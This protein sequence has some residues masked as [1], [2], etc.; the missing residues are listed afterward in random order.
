M[1]KTIK[2]IFVLFLFSIKLFAQKE[3]QDFCKGDVKGS[4]F[5]LEISK[6][7]I[8]W[9]TTSYTEEL[10]GEK[11]IDGNLY[12]VF[13]QLWENGDKYTLYLREVNN[14][15]FEY[16]LKSKKDFIRY[17]KTFD[18]NHTWK[19]PNWGNYKLLS[20]TDKLATPYCVYNNLMSIE[21]KINKQTY[22]FYYLKGYGYVGAVKDKTVISYVSPEVKFD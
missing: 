7:K 9:Y 10:I 18:I 17:D 4:Y 8:H 6:K 22:I 16:D 1:N 11:N 3:G 14:I 21:V 12:K 5:P 19:T 20:Y 15:V 13:D 2:L